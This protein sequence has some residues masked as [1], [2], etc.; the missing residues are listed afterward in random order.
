MLDD[1]FYTIFAYNDAVKEK[2]GSKKSKAKSL[3]KGKYSEGTITAG[4]SSSDWYK[5]KSSAKTVKV[6]LRGYS[7]TSGKTKIT[8]TKGKNKLSATVMR[9]GG[10]DKELSMTNWGSGTYY[11]Q[12][13]RGAS[14]SSG[15][16][17][18]EYQ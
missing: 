4:S 13:A 5:F 7:S 9:G 17:E 10:A 3:T 8:V 2:S 18:V 15:Y 11:V 6:T 12:V 1:G 16:Y 14:K